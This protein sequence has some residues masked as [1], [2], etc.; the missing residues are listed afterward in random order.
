MKLTD[1]LLFILMALL[2]TC[3][4][5]LIHQYS[6]DMPMPA[7]WLKRPL[8]LLPM[9]GAAVV[10]F[11]GLG[12]WV[13]ALAR[14]PMSVG[15]PVGIGLSLVSSTFGGMLVLN[16]P[17]GL[18]KLAGLGAILVGAVVIGRSSREPPAA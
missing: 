17:V 1:F 11:S 9:A 15:Y 6:H 7:E 18:L 3:G 16:E 12:L 14:T 5:I 2:S 4:L 8:D 10:Y 13:V